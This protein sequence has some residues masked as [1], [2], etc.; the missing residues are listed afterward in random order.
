MLLKTFC[1][2]VLRFF[3]KK[4]GCSGVA[5]RAFVDWLNEVGGW[6]DD[7]KRGHPQ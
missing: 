5:R 2:V 3:W 1:E 7:R 4:A 6:E